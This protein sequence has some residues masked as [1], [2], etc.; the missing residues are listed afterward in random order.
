MSKLR[1]LLRLALLSA[2]EVSGGSTGLA[3]LSRVDCCSE[4]TPNADGN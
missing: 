4:V 2:H 3:L 1:G